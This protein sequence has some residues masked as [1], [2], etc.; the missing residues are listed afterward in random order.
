MS[1][2]RREA[3]GTAVLVWLT[4]YVV[5]LLAVPSWLVIGPLG[6]AGAPSMLLGLASGLVWL[7]AQLPRPTGRVAHSPIRMALVLFLGCVG[8]SYAIAMAGPIDWDEVSPADL[9]LLVM[10]SWSGV[11]LLVHDGL[12]DERAVETLVRR[13]SYVGGLMATLG[14]AQF[15]T[16]TLLIDGLD[17]PGLRST[18]AVFASFRNGLLRMSGTATSPI[19]FGALLTILLPLG[20]HHALYGTTRSRLLRWSPAA[21]MAGALVLSLS[22]SAY[23][24]LVVAL[25]VLLLGWPSRRRWQLMGLCA[26]GVLVVAVVSPRLLRAVRSMFATA[27][28]DPSISSRTDSYDVVWQFFLNAPWFGRGPGTFLPKYRILD[29]NYLGLLINVGLVGLL[30]FVGLLL[31][32]VVLLLVHRRRW[33]RESSRD[34]ALALVAG[35]LAGAV[36]LAFFDGFAFP[37]TMGTLFLTLGLAGALVRVHREPPAESIT[38]RVDTGSAH[39]DALGS[40]SGQKEVRVEQSA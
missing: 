12:E 10:L 23:I 3:E 38:G 22:R 31:T 29:N 32:A 5:I 21:A 26:A 37:M 15:L 13:V 30:A 20:L 34:L 7:L 27:Q 16:G 33:A 36:S 39:R 18:G 17:V 2:Q 9:S 1:Q 8:V 19:E 25:V 14:L 6:S 35:I 40:G 4:G 11:L 28:E 24:G